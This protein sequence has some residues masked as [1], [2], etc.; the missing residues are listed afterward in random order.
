MN[1]GKALLTFL[2]TKNCNAFLSEQ[3]SFISKRAFKKQKNNPLPLVKCASFLC[4]SFGLYCV[5]AFRE[6]IRKVENL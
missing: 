4:S 2:K 6:N 1:I 5:I 3:L